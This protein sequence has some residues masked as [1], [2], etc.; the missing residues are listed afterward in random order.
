MTKKVIRIL[1]G[2]EN[3]IARRDFESQNFGYTIYGQDAEPEE[4]ARYEIADEAEARKEFGKYRCSYNTY[5]GGSNWS[6]TEYALDFSEIEE[7]EDGFIESE[8]P[9]KKHV[10]AKMDMESFINIAK[11]QGSVCLCGDDITVDIGCDSYYISVEDIIA[12]IL[13][14]IDSDRNAEEWGIFYNQ[15]LND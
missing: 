15:Y 8:S 9:I 4:V 6:I 13:E 7:D 12:P 3:G 10:L 11:N 2:E 5:D 1:Q 14:K